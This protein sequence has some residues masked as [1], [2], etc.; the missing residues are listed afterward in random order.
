VP[1]LTLVFDPNTPQVVYAGGY[2]Q[3]GLYDSHDGGQTWTAAANG[4][5]GPVYA[6]LVIPTQSD[7]LLAGTASGLYRRKDDGSGWQRLPG[8]PDPL[9]VYALAHDASGALYL[10]GDRP[11]AF[12]SRDGG[13]SWEPLTPLPGETSILALAVS[14]GG[15]R[16][17]AGTEGQGLFL[18]SD[19]GHTWQP[20]D[21]VGQAIVAGLW[22]V[23]Q[24]G[25]DAYART[26]RGLFRTTD[27]G[28]TWQSA[29]TNVEDR[30]DTL[31]LDPTTGWLYL[32][33]SGGYVYRSRAGSADWELWGQ[34]L[35][36]SGT[37]FTLHMAPGRPGV[38]FA[39]AEA[40]L[41]RS[42]DGGLHWQE[43]DQGPGYPSATAL[44]MT[45]DGTLFL[46]TADGVYGSVDGGEHWARRSKG[47]PATNVLSLAVSPAEPDLIYAGLGGQGVYRST[48]AGQTWT[49]RGL[50]RLSVMALA[51][52]PGDPQR[53]YARVA[54]ERVYESRDG[55]ATW[56]A[57]WEGLGLSTEIIS[58][59]IDP[60]QPQTLYA[61]GTQG[62]FKSQDGGLSWQKTGRELDGQ[63]IFALMVDR[64]RPD[65]LYAGATQGAYRS[66]DAGQ[67]WTLWGSGLEDITVTALA[68]HPQQAGVVYAGTKYR[69]VYRSG[70]GGRTWRPASGME[71]TN[72]N[73]DLSR[74]S[75]NSLV[76]SP[77]G[78]WLYAATS[79]GFYRGV[80]R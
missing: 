16:L 5:E 66:T 59:V 28:Q 10:A 39:G 35:A 62:L 26:E 78:R 2:A 42:D 7:G 4:P 9:V 43:A 13:K 64:A 19:W 79:Y 58:V 38:W 24:D 23:S 1:V 54:F 80:A 11:Q 30:V 55:G 27:G 51:P 20:V 60:H 68:F 77:D 14:A 53:L 71:T 6:L 8:L 72:T 36:R 25:L 34:G 63:T 44:A 21:E 41:Y 48:D 3:P 29:A 65:W 75:V 37:V 17:L 15:D 22:F 67:S 50:G 69:G 32:A 40:G 52:H 61:G 31:T 18:S 12:R 46:G 56:A 33:T 73:S 74:A 76:A 47:L 49:A 45:P 70:D 57:R